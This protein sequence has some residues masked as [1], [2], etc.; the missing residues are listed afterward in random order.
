MAASPRLL[1][2]LRLA[3]QARTYLTYLEGLGVRHLP[4]PEG[5]PLPAD[6]LDRL[7]ES[8]V[9]VRE[10]VG[11][12]T[13]C[14]LS[15]DRRSIVFGEGAGRAAL[16]LVGEAPR[17]P[18]DQEGRPFLGEPGRLLTDIL[19][20]GLGQSR[21]AC[22]LTTLVKCRPAGDRPPF[23]LE[24]RTCRQFLIRQIVSIRPQVILT[25][26][27]STS[28]AL[29]ETDQPLSRL[30]GRFHDFHGFSVL[31]TYHPE[32]ILKNADLRR[33]TWEDVKMVI[34]RLKGQA[35]SI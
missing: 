14:P 29:I 35:G 26:G 3:R 15:R 28:Q 21:E 8:L 12:C 22:Y 16:M 31:P 27:Q 11:E 20:K 34:T 9:E 7:S 18:D 13:R 25:L 6:A 17:G 1:E 33:P 5:V 30:R 10:N 32:D 23:S 24:L 2:L 4:K 19:V